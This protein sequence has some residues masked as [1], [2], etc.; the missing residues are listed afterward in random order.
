MLYSDVTSPL[1]LVLSF[2]RSVFLPDTLMLNR[3]RTAHLALTEIRLL[4]N[5]HTQTYVVSP[6]AV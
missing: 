1:K 5:T 3:N 4:L 2:K 6:V